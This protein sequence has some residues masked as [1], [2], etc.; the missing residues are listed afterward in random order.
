MEGE[1]G[2][3]GGWWLCLCFQQLRG[4]S[5]ECRPPRRQWLV[6]YQARAWRALQPPPSRCWGCASWRTGFSTFWIS[7]GQAGGGSGPPW[8][9]ALWFA[10]S[11]STAPAT[12]SWSAWTSSAPCQWL[13]EG[14]PWSWSP[15]PTGEHGCCSH[16][17]VGRAVGSPCQGGGYLGWASDSAEW[18][19][20]LDWA[21]HISGGE[22]ATF[23]PGFPWHLRLP[24]RR[25]KGSGYRAHASL[26][27]F[28]KQGKLAWDV[29]VALPAPRQERRPNEQAVTVEPP[30]IPELEERIQS[31]CESGDPRWLAL[32]SAW[33]QTFGILRYKHIQRAIPV[34]VTNAAF[35]ARCLKGK[36]RQN[37]KGFDFMV[38]GSFCNGW[39]WVRPH[40]WML[41]TH[42]LKMPSKRA[43]CASLWMGSLGACMRWQ[44]SFKR[45]SPICWWTQV[46]WPAIVGV[47]P[48]LPLGNCSNS[49][50][51]TWQLLEI[52]RIAQRSLHKLQCPCTTAVL[53]MMPRSVSSLWCVRPLDRSLAMKHGRSC[54][55]MLCRRLWPMVAVASTACST[56]TL[57]PCGVHRSDRMSWRRDCGWP[58]PWSRR[59]QIAA[60]RA[61]ETLGCRTC[62]PRALCG[63]FQTRVCTFD[64]KACAGLH[65]CAVMRNSGR[66]CGGGH[67]AIDCYDKKLMRVESFTEGLQHVP[68][69][70]SKG[71]HVKPKSPSRSPRRPRSP[72]ISPLRRKPAGEQ[73]SSSRKRAAPAPALPVSDTGAGSAKDR[74]KPWLEKMR[75]RAAEERAAKRAKKEFAAEGTVAVTGSV[76]ESG[77]DR[78]YDLLAV[79]DRKTALAPSLIWTSPEGGQLWLSG[80]PLQKTIGSYPTVALQL[81]CMGQTPPCLEQWRGSCRLGA[82]RERTPS[83]QCVPDRETDISHG[84]STSWRNMAGCLLRAI[85]AEEDWDRAVAEVKKI[86]PTLDI[87]GAMKDVVL[88]KWVRDTLGK[89]KLQAPLPF[90]VA[91]LYVHTS[92]VRRRPS[93]WSFPT[94]RP[95]WPKR[96]IGALLSAVSA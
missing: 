9:Y 38:P 86:R 7:W 60:R 96:P 83:R 34:R 90:P 41:G 15:S 8:S 55:K 26:R 81:C 14:F 11:K 33:I 61:K 94:P 77:P 36:Q 57:G 12:W 85:L 42:S 50:P 5:H 37:R 29:G 40:G 45:L 58:R 25:R 74:P 28:V 84:G 1:D 16:S 35:H 20:D 63:A 10:T 17:L 3:G 93:A 75:L 73:P 69:P 31:M 48:A 92:S 71:G 95:A 88:K 47:G 89:T 21:S 19:Q 66:V 54:P 46:Y 53:A 56:M 65:R 30:M 32:L 13:E 67:A 23:S 24:E 62:H 87:P 22:G 2:P 72:S 78:H 18:A 59:W 79:S 44:R 52:G 64:D 39:G 76:A 6:A 43:D 49:R 82:K 27:W 70:S 4:G 91:S 80:L 51:W 68:Q